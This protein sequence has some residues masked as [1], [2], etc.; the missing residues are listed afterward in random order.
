MQIQSRFKIFVAIIILFLSYQSAIAQKLWVESYKQGMVVSAEKLASE[1]GRDILKKGGNAVDAATA[2]NFALAVTYPQAGNL[3]GGGFMVIH[4]AQGDNISLDFREVA[5]RK[6]KQDMLLDRK[7]NYNSDKARASALAAGVPGTVDG[8]LTALERYGNLP[9]DIVLEPAIKLAREGYKLTAYQAKILNSYLDEFNKY[10]STRKYFTP[11]DADSF[12]TGDIFAQNDLAETIQRIASF[13]K[14]GFYSGQ[15]ADQIVETIKENNGLIDYIDLKN[16]Q[17]KWREP[18][19]TRYKDYELSMMPPPSSG[20]VV[21]TQILEMLSGY[22]LESLGF[23]SASYIHLLTETMKR[24]YADRNYYL[25][26]PDFVQ[27][28]LGVLQSSFYNKDRINGFSWDQVT[29]SEQ[30]NH[31]RVPGLEE[32]YETT[33]YSVVDKFGNAVSVTTTLNS[34]FGNK[35]VVDGAGFFLNNEMDDF[36]SK[37]GTPNQF[38]LVQGTA[39]KIE[40]NKRMLSSMTPTIVTKNKNVRMILGAAGGPRIIT[41]V[42]QTFLNKAVFDMNASQ[43][44]SSGR[45]HHQW[46]PDFTYIEPF[47]VTSDTEEILLEKGHNIK[48]ISNIGRSHIIYI[49]AAGVKTGGADPRGNGHTAGY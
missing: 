27:I 1:I 25:A 12:K 38:G 10:E 49:D 13:G 15:T 26:D 35:I 31:G 19:T 18:V 28:P 40:P 39:N 24:A 22:D 7:G 36:T 6:A 32:S 37:P 34:L 46:L 47:A 48:K 3:G 33:H 20:G 5:P 41:T 9:I 4:L 8:M 2:V 30:I 14:N 43:S 16:Y 23:N 44:I 21:I 29:S 45:F 17:S 11:A 42:L